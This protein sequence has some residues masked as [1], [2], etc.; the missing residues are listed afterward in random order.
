MAHIGKN[1]V[2][3]PP[4]GRFSPDFGLSD[5]SPRGGITKAYRFA[6]CVCR[7]TRPARA[8]RHRLAKRR[9]RWPRWLPGGANDDQNPPLPSW[10]QSL[11]ESQGGRRSQL[12]YVRACGKR[13]RRARRTGTRW[14]HRCGSFS[15]S[16]LRTEHRNTISRRCVRPESA[17]DFG[18]GACRCDRSTFGAK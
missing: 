13:I 12:C 14:P 10:R 17:R 11:P 6:R 4:G 18:V 9:P 15:R 7:P 3:Y 1:G 2:T 5:S 8:T 16:D